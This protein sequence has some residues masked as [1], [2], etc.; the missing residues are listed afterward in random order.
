[1]E[2]NRI[3]L[4]EESDLKDMKLDL[5][6]AEDTEWGE[7]IDEEMEKEICELNKM[8]NLEDDDDE[9]EED[10]EEDEEQEEE[11]EEILKDL[12]ESDEENMKTKGRKE[13]E[14][15]DGENEKKKVKKRIKGTEF[16]LLMKKSGFSEKDKEMC[17]N[18]K[19]N[20]YGEANYENAFNGKERRNVMRPVPVLFRPGTNN[21]LTDTDSDSDDEERFYDGED[22]TRIVNGKSDFVYDTPEIY[23][24]QLPPVA[25]VRNGND[26]LSNGSPGED[27][28]KEI[29]TQI[30]HNEAVAGAIILSTDV[31][32]EILREDCP[33]TD[34]GLM[35]QLREKYVVQP[36]PSMFSVFDKT[37]KMTGNPATHEQVCI[38]S[39][40]GKE[41][42]F[43]RK[44]G[45]LDWKENRIV[46]IDVCRVKDAPV[47]RHLGFWM[48]RGVK[49]SSVSM[50]TKGTDQRPSIQSFICNVTG[51]IWIQT[52]SVNPDDS[53]DSS[54]SDGDALISMYQRGGQCLIDA[55]QQ[56]WETD[57]TTGIVHAKTTPL[58]NGVTCISLNASP[59]EPGATSV[60]RD[61]G[62]AICTSLFLRL[63]VEQYLAWRLCIIKKMGG[64]GEYVS[65][66]C[67]IHAA[68]G[69]SDR[70]NRAHFSWA[71]PKKIQRACAWREFEI[72]TLRWL[73]LVA[74]CAGSPARQRAT[75]VFREMGLTSAASARLSTLTLDDVTRAIL[76]EGGVRTRQRS[77][78]V[79]AMIVAFAT[80]VPL[81]IGKAKTAKLQG[82][83]KANVK[84]PV[85]EPVLAP[86]ED[87]VPAP[88]KDPVSA[89]V[90]K[91]GQALVKTLETMESPPKERMITKK[92]KSSEGSGEADASMKKKE[93]KKKRG[94][95]LTSVGTSQLPIPSVSI[96]ST[97]STAMRT[98]QLALAQLQIILDQSPI[99]AI[100]EC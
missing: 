48:P 25:V 11:E 90:D 35:R 74:G 36:T 79:G 21:P 39:P 42:L 37:G 18:Q 57:L 93:K 46:Q 17:V 52:D 87:T 10:D 23:Q 82:E 98:A 66:E 83:Q 94:A 14:V 31:S 56:T 68:V 15:E 30:G 13:Y 62:G 91:P 32:I 86:V 97:L 77:P 80:G 12:V 59:T 70:V 78:E 72:N 44:K 6:Y 63:L 89:P 76:L 55:D 69:K 41:Q 4:K 38:H 96:P 40:E 34:E 58:L 99:G 95:P 22:L 75:T 43:V 81:P 45:E 84:V 85:D 28:L 73:E 16:D 88:V 5:K 67:L 61:D 3:E 53:N 50:R 51:E 27:I 26:L 20:I 33:V 49:A 92:R 19:R 60:V 2:K 100:S 71:V 47:G 8:D 24:E 7:K 64:E 54:D 1:M 29:G 9:E 65:S